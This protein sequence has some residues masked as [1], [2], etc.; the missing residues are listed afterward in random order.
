MM[1]RWLPLQEMGW[2]SHPASRLHHLEVHGVT[3]CGVLEPAESVT[4]GQGS[5]QGPHGQTAGLWHQREEHLPLNGHNPHHIQAVLSEGASLWRDKDRSFWVVTL[6]ALEPEQEPGRGSFLPED[7]CTFSSYCWDH[8]CLVS[9]P[10][11][12]LGSHLSSLPSL[13]QVAPALGPCPWAAHHLL[14]EG[15]I[16]QGSPFLGDPP[17]P[18]A[19]LALHQPGAL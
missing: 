2:P 3:H 15:W 1:P 14:T 9:V 16:S 10:G 6:G 19:H 17:C 18:A 13:G 7:L 11:V 4:G 8:P 12:P 5:E